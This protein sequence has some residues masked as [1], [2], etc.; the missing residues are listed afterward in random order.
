MVEAAANEMES[1]TLFQD[2]LPD[3][4]RT[5]VILETVWRGVEIKFGT[6]CKR[7]G[8]GIDAYVC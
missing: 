4:Q 7:G 3:P 8:T 5:N 6:D 2:P 1:V